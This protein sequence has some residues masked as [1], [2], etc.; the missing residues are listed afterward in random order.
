MLFYCRTHLDLF[1]ISFCST[2]LKNN[3]ISILVKFSADLELK[4]CTSVS[5][6]NQIVYN[7]RILHCFPALQTLE[8]PDMCLGDNVKLLQNLDGVMQL[9]IIIFETYQPLVSIEWSIQWKNVENC[10][11]QSDVI[12]IKFYGFWVVVKH[13]TWTCTQFTSVFDWNIL[14]S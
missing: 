5:T 3:L 12:R 2:F 9:F 7:V 4:I 1:N 6:T 14:I 13:F 8:H 10:L 11:K